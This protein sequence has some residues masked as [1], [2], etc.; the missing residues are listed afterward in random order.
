MNDDS[1]RPVD[2]A[3]QGYIDAIRDRIR[4][5]L[6]AEVD[7]LSFPGRM[8]V[9]LTGSGQVNRG[10]LTTLVGQAGTPFSGEEAG[11]DPDGVLTRLAVLVELVHRA[12]VIHDDIQDGDLLRRGVPTFHV[13]EG[14]PMAIAVADVLLSRAFTLAEEVGIAAVLEDTIATYQRMSRGQLM[15]FA[16]LDDVPGA[17]WTL[18]SELKTG[19]LVELAFRCG[20]HAA[21]TASDLADA[22]GEVGRLCG[23][24]F[25]MVNDLRNV[26][27]QEDRQATVTDLAAGRFSAIRL[28]SEQVFGENPADSPGR[29][30]AVCDAVEQEVHR[31]MAAATGLLASISPPGFAS[32]VLT[33][34]T[35]SSASMRFAL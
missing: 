2:A 7:A 8:L 4:A 30:A 11:S 26:R 28:Y 20:A 17:D 35:S 14:V 31:R 6:R 10:V 9:L 16:G 25:Q 24:A 18:P 3:W 1:S 13:A 32:R 34:L 15:D 29:L 21:G 5:A 27:A 23:S 22:W 12:S 33:I 19:S